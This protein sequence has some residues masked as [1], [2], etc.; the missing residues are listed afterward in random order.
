VADNG[1]ASRDD[2]AADIERFYRVDRSRRPETGGADL[3]L[4]IAKRLWKRTR[5]H[6]G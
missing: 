4:T 3:G 2:P 5:R 6:R 1:E